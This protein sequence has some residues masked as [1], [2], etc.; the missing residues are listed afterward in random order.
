MTDKIIQQNFT[1]PDGVNVVTRLYFPK[2]LSEMPHVRVFID[3][4]MTAILEE[5]LTGQDLRVLMLCISEMEY[6]NI[7]NKSQAELAEKLG[8]KQQ[9]VA[10]SIKKLIDGNLL[11]VIGKIGRQNVYRV[12]PLFAF[13]SRAKNLKGLIEAWYDVQEAS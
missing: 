5:S 3:G 10:K 13:K 1:V 8:I 9:H 4:I 2:H 7:L 6:E 12:S 11:Q